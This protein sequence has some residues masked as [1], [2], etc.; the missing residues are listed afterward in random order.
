MIGWERI[1]RKRRKVRGRKKRRTSCIK[2][3]F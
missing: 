1:G 2:N 3:Y